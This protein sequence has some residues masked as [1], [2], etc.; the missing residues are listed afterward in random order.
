MTFKYTDPCLVT[1]IEG[2]SA[3]LNFVQFEG[4]NTT[5]DSSNKFTDSMST[6]IGVMPEICGELEVSYDTKSSLT[7]AFS[8]GNNQPIT[9]NSNFLNKV[10]GTFRVN[11]IVKLKNYPTVGPLIIPFDATILASVS[12]L[13]SS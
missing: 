10:Y 2:T 3:A 7:S 9:F 5:T 13:I 6:L 8:G 11:Q 4:F 12:P 1:T